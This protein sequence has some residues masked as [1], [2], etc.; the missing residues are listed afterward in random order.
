VQEADDERDA[1][2]PRR[3]GRHLLRRDQSGD[4]VAP[5]FLR[6]EAHHEQDVRREDQVVHDVGQHDVALARQRVVVEDISGI[7]AAEP[8]DERPQPHRDRDEDEDDC[9]FEDPPG[10]FEHSV[11]AGGQGEDCGGR[12]GHD[13]HGGGSRADAGASP[14]AVGVDALDDPVEQVR[15][16]AGR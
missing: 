15:G 2:H 13:G 6:R 8:L 12:H 3:R 10:H 14:P 16:G 7:G 5:G 1:A 11:P 4:L 9:H